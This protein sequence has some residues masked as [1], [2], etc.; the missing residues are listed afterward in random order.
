MDKEPKNVDVTKPDNCQVPQQIGNNS[1]SVRM[2][3]E[4]DLQKV[5]KP[6]I[7]DL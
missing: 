1:N 6:E 5:I 4:C 3:S 2:D 7:L